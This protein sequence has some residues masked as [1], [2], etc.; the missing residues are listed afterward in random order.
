MR[1]NGLGIDLKQHRKR[2]YGLYQR[3][4]DSPNSKGLGLYLVKTQLELL[5]GKIEVESEVGI[6][7]TFTIYLRDQAKSS[8]QNS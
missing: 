8:R 1:D 5:D 4:H 6:G 7:T 2:L 3:F